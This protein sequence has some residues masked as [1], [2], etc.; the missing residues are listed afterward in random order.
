M[1]DAVS[2]R[3]IEFGRNDGL[4][5]AFVPTARFRQEAACLPDQVRP[6]LFPARA[7]AAIRPV[8]G[9]AEIG[10]ERCEGFAGAAELQATAHP[11]FKGREPSMQREARR[12][13]RL[14]RRWT[15]AP[16]AV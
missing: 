6:G 11:R 16:P 9:T 5:P 15:Q 8:A 2:G 13:A 12:E 1:L 3:A 7:T 4:G 14:R 10:N